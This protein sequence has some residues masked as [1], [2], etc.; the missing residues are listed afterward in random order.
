MISRWHLMYASKRHLS[1]CANA[2]FTTSL[3]NQCKPAQWSSWT[4]AAQMLLSLRAVSDSCFEQPPPGHPRHL[5]CCSSTIFSASCCHLRFPLCAFS[6]MASRSQRVPS[7]CIRGV[8]FKSCPTAYGLACCISCSAW[9]KALSC[10]LIIVVPHLA[11]QPGSG[12]PVQD[13]VARPGRSRPICKL[14]H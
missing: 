10:T 7:M 13:G 14:R 9:C 6:G 4:S 2:P 5:D 3:G 12:N 1:A 11:F 8:Y